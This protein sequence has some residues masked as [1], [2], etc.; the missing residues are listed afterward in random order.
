M[1][2]A[3]CLQVQIPLVGDCQAEACLEF[4]EPLH[5]KLSGGG[6]TQP[7]S[8]MPLPS[9]IQEWA[10]EHR[11]ARKRANAAD[12]L[13]YE[14][15]QIHREEWSEDVWEINASLPERQGRPMSEGYLVRDPLSPLDPVV[16]PRHAVYAYGVLSNGLRAYTWVYRSGELVM[17][18]TLLGHG[19]HLGR[20]VMYLLMRGALEHQVEVGPGTAFYNRHDSGTPGLVFFKERVGFKPARVE[21]SL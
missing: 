4:A 13:G 19:D 17:F 10:A 6:Y 9:S 3:E 18:S 8:V 21:W 15:G 11:T 1:T 20:H 7:V 14:V 12:R 5:E 16:C 2:V